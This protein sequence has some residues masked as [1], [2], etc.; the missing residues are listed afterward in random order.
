LCPPTTTTTTT[1]APSPDAHC[2]DLLTCA[3]CAIGVKDEI[4]CSDSCWDLA[5]DWADTLAAATSCSSPIDDHCSLKVSPPNRGVIAY[6]I[7]CQVRSFSSE[8]PTSP[9]LQGQETMT[10]GEGNE[11]AEYAGTTSNECEEESTPN[12]MGVA[13]YSDGD[14]H[15]RTRY[16]GQMQCGKRHGRGRLEWKDGAVYVGDFHRGAREG[17]GRMEYADG[18]VYDG[19]FEK[20]VKHGFGVYVGQEQV[21]VGPFSGGKRHGRDAEVFSARE[22]DR[23][24]FSGEFRDDARLVGKVELGRSQYEGSLAADGLPE[25]QGRWDDACGNFYSGQWRNGVKEAIRVSDRTKC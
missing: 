7:D 1:S 23:L 24:M 20:D 15:N 5:Y 13:I 2:P 16:V 19:Q 12:G 21:Y 4:A 14:R 6:N 18:R 9:V 22:P 3:K 8:T 10:M 11:R 25:G 17:K